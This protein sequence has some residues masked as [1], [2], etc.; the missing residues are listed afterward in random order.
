MDEES[1][2]NNREPCDLDIAVDVFRTCEN[3]EAICAYD[4]GVAR[5]DFSEEYLRRSTDRS[6][7]LALIAQLKELTDEVK[8]LR[9]NM[10]R[11][12]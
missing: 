10:N 5:G 11:G 4:E 1:Q 3:G 2:N 8:M 7:M 12:A 9:V 6:F